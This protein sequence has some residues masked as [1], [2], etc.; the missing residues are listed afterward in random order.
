MSG[1]TTAH[2]GGRR[3]VVAAGR[4]FRPRELRRIVRLSCAVPL[5][6]A[7]RPRGKT[8][9]RHTGRNDGRGRD[10]TK[11]KLVHVSFL[12][13]LSTGSLRHRPES[14]RH[15]EEAEGR[16]SNLC[17]ESCTSEAR[18]LRFARNDGDE[19]TY[20]SGF[21][22]TREP[23]VGAERGMGNTH[24]PAVSRSQFCFKPVPPFWIGEPRPPI[25]PG[26]EF[27]A[28][29]AKDRKSRVRRSE[30]RPA[31]F[32]GKIPR[33]DQLGVSS[34]MSRHAPRKRGIQ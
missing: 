11:H 3:T 4:T 32:S 29:L 1:V 2:D 13:A 19:P 33:T 7:I 25:S 10:Q 9:D 30:E 28:T 8:E 16:R 27:G 5:D 21:S 14:S 22:R 18:L 31:R 24:Q 34:S 12:V 23:P 6:A 17:Q 15:C 26:G 20:S